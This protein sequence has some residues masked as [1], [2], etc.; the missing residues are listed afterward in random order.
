MTRPTRKPRPSIF[1]GSDMGMPHP[2]PEKRTS[3][4]IFTNPRFHQGTTMQQTQEAH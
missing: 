1:E 2:T 4:P 3:D